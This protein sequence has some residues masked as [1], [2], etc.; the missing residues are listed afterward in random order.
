M[1]AN[2]RPYLIGIT[3]NIGSGKSTFCR[4]LERR[5]QRVIYAD[6]V[7][8]KYLMLLRELWVKR[9]GTDI[10]DRGALDKAKIADIIFDQPAERHYLNSEIHPLVLQDFQSIVE[11]SGEARV[12]FEIP[13]LFETNLAN[14][15]DFIILIMAK[16]EIV[17]Q[18]IM[19]R[20]H[21]SYADIQKRLA[22]QMPDELKASQVDLVIDNSGNIDEL[23]KKVQSFLDRLNTLRF[24]AVKPFNL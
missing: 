6:A 24:K 20:D 3:G 12:Y 14:C 1:L 5:G 4:E 10:L 17:M 8:E 19:E 7:A 16:Q 13:L 23:R 15:F 11:Q 9:W 21:S 22:A 18:R 2:K